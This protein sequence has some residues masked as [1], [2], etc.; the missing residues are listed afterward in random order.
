[1]NSCPDAVIDNALVVQVE[2]VEIDARLPPGASQGKCL[3]DAEV[4]G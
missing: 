4:V 2:E 3:L 1:L